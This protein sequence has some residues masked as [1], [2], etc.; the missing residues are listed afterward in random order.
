[1]IDAF[2]PLLGTFSALS[3]MMTLLAIHALYALVRGIADLRSGR[4]KWGIL[5]LLLFLTYL[6]AMLVPI[7]F[8][9][10]QVDV[11]RT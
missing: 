6:F 9:G 8:L 2:A 1:M 4:K 7:D 11:I 10:P 5:G 3:L